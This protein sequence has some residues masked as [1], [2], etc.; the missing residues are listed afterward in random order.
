MSEF[1]P[2]L[3]G[4]P[5]YDEALQQASAIRPSAESAVAVKYEK[6]ELGDTRCIMEHTSITESDKT[7]KL[8]FLFK[9]ASMPVMTQ[10]SSQLRQ[11]TEQLNIDG[12]AAEAG[13]SPLS[14]KQFDFVLFGVP[15]FRAEEIRG[16]IV[17]EMQELFRG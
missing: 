13:V 5:E 10:L 17:R 1:K 11:I 12:S 15:T 16:Y 4:T 14:K 2:I 3:P 6:V 9:M 8:V 7:S